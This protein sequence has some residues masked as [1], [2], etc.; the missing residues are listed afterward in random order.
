MKL[1]LHTWGTEGDIRPFFALAA[2][3]VARGHQ[4]RV[5]YACVDG[6]DLGALARAA[7][8]ADEAIAAAYYRDHHATILAHARARVTRRCWSRSTASAP[9]CGSTRSRRSPPCPPPTPAPC[10]TA[11]AGRCR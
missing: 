6:A 1:A 2:A 8:V 11:A 5:A 4:V 9:R 3:L 10:S 7:G